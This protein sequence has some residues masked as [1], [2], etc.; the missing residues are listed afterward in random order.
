MAAW[1]QRIGGELRVV[2]VFMQG[3]TPSRTRTRAKNGT[4]AEAP[5]SFA[6]GDETQHSPELEVRVYS[7]VARRAD[8]TRLC[9]LEQLLLLDR[10]G[11]GTNA[12]NLRK[13]LE[14]RLIGLSREQLGA[15]AAICPRPRCGQPGPWESTST[16][17]ER[18][19]SSY[20]GPAAARKAAVRHVAVSR[21]LAVRSASA[22]EDLAEELRV[23]PD[24]LPAAV[25]AAAS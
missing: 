20:S 6:E 23:R 13:A 9:P 4:E 10:A 14:P 15:S 8:T 24:G 16:V 1:A 7:P 19:R 12:T 3:H 25:V 11:V 22:W 2:R 21:A 5:R 17:P 18:P